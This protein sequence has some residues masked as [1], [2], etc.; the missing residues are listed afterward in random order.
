MSGIVG[1]AGSKS[2]VIGGN[3]PKHI[4]IFSPTDH[5]SSGDN[6]NLAVDLAKIDNELPNYTSY[7]TQS[8]TTLTIVKAGL[9]Y[10]S[11][12]GLANTDESGGDLNCYLAITGYG[13]QR[14]RNPSPSGS[15][16]WTSGHVAGTFQLVA[17][18]TIIGYL[19]NPVTHTLH[20]HHGE[21]WTSIDVTYLGTGK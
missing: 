18:N 19:G 8:G 11:F 16:K 5:S 15:D 2:G 3:S 14:Q 6:V 20:H 7:L 9:Y 12:K 13:V 21:E 4:G 10:V 1:G 17:G